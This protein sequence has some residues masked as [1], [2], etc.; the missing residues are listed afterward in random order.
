MPRIGHFFPNSPGSR[1]TPTPVTRRDHALCGMSRN[2]LVHATP[3]DERCVVCLLLLR[4]LNQVDSTLP[5]YIKGND[6][7]PGRFAHIT[8]AEFTFLSKPVP[9]LV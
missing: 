1:L 8:P 4:G 7:F 9:A 3:G 5:T 2:G 6:D